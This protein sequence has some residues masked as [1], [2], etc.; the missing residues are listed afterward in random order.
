MNTHTIR[1]IYTPSE[2]AGGMFEN[3]GTTSELFDFKS[4][5]IAVAQAARNGD[6]VV[7][8]GVGGTVH[9]ICDGQPDPK[10]VYI[11]CQNVQLREHG[12]PTFMTEPV[13]RPQAHDAVV[14]TSHEDAKTGLP[15]GYEL[16]SLDVFHPPST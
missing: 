4:L 15:W 12:E 14:Y 16:Y 8:E 11:R 13:Y 7:L 5:L 9:V 3:N 6:K 1:S 10:K 2:P